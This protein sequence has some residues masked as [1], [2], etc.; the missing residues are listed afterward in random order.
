MNL[1]DWQTRL[2]SHFKLLKEQRDPSDSPVF[3][4]EHGLEKLELTSLQDSIHEF[5]LHTTPSDKHWLAWVVYATELGYTYSG[6]EYWNSFALRTPGWD[7]HNQNVARYAIRD[8]FWRFRRDCS[9]F[10]PT[11]PWANHFSIIC[12]P[13]THAILPQDLQ[14][15][16]AEA[17][18]D[19]RHEYDEQLLSNPEKLGEY[20]KRASWK[21]SS[22]FQQ[23]AEQEF[24]VGQ[25]ASALLQCD[26]EEP[27]NGLILGTTLSRITADLDQ[28]R[29]SREWLSG[30]RRHAFTIRTGGLNR[31]GVLQGPRTHDSQDEISS[32]R[33]APLGIEPSLSL[34][35]R[36]SDTWEIRL[37]LQSLST[38]LLK[39]PK[40]KPYL[41]GERCYVIGAKDR[42]PIARSGLLFG[43]QEVPLSKW[44]SKGAVLLRFERS[45]PE[46][47]HILSTDA[48]LRPGPYWLFKVGDDGDAAEI[49]TGSIRLGTNYILL[50][51]VSP[52]LWGVETEPVATDCDGINAILLRI[53]RVISSVVTREL[54]RIGLSVASSLNCWPVGLVPAK[55]DD[56]GAAE[57]L[58]TDN[59]CFAF[60]S[61][62]QCDETFLNL[63][64][65]NSKTLQLQR[66]IGPEP[67]FLE[68]GPLNAGLHTLHVIATHNEH[69][70]VAALQLSV[71]D[72]VPI[73]NALGPLTI[74]ISPSNPTLEELWDGTAEIEVYAPKTY[75]SAVNSISFG[76]RP[77]Q[78]H[79]H[80]G[81]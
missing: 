45:C 43:A 78:P 18:F 42:R 52:V 26:N 40:F 5:S 62:F 29:R 75:R 53:P 17:L 4:L 21:M 41:T 71:R 14:R 51:A 66:G 49:R 54:G 16:L 72:S 61:D 47:D 12:W 35:F 69:Q 38:L 15:Q 81:R 80:R 39:F 2:E 23:F 56:E 22:R 63:V 67:T 76:R 55:W 13:I 36:G 7:K 64:G 24:L 46:L 70:I 3:A 20:I 74:A 68:L 27:G 25:I 32:D 60:E 65:P 9:G 19:I 8:A 77:R 30:A 6:E 59:P 44:P 1:N 33:I 57:F 10:T 11:G 37:R 73:A 50:S 48:L 31:G 28:E 79:L 58:T 34:R